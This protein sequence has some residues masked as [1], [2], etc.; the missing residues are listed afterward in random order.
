[1]TKKIS[2][3]E[4]SSSHWNSVSGGTEE[5]AKTECKTTLST[6]SKTVKVDGSCKDENGNGY[7][8]TVY[9][10]TQK[11]SGGAEIVVYWTTD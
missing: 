5:I 9:W 7:G 3:Q 1:M 8:G 11:K 6:D 4:I 10:D 2:L